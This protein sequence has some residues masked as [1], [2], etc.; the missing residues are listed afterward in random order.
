MVSTTLDQ[1]RS[2]LKSILLLIFY[3]IAF[4]TKRILVTHLQHFTMDFFFYFFKP[5][6][7]K[8]LVWNN[9]YYLMQNKIS[10]S[11]QSKVRWY[12]LLWRPRT[13]V[14]G[15]NSCCTVKTQN[16][17]SDKYTS[18]TLFNIQVRQQPFSANT[19]SKSIGQY[20]IYLLLYHGNK[21]GSCYLATSLSSVIKH[22]HTQSQ[23]LSITQTSTSIIYLPNKM[24]DSPQILVSWNSVVTY[25]AGDKLGFMQYVWG[26]KKSEKEILIHW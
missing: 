3:V 14:F 4:L 21:P 1:K 19:L 15:Q 8:L 20:Q 23:Q 10:E 6:L 5:P 2:D 25:L 22:M 7:F 26:K 9:I 12:H 16:N 24:E 11:P 13:V 18:F 17:L